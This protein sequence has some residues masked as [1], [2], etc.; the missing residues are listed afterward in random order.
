MSECPLCSDNCVGCCSGALQASDMHS[1]VASTSM[2]TIYTESTEA[3]GMF[4]STVDSNDIRWNGMEL[5][6]SL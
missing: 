3:T 2:S 6:G 4:R 1:C 5:D